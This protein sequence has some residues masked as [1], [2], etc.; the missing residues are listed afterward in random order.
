MVFDACF[1][2]ARLGSAHELAELLDPAPAG[3]TTLSLDC[4]DTLLWL[5]VQARRA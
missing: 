3:L 2:G 4:F 1:S 5:D